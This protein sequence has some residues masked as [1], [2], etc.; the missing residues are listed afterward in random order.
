MGSF[1]PG[2][3]EE[4]KG[5]HIL[6]VFWVLTSITLV[7]VLARL[8]IRLRV[9]RNPGADDWL[10]AA[11]MIVGMAYTCLTTVN[12]SLGFGRHSA[13]IAD[14]L[15]TV[16]LLNYI[17]F[18]LGIL[19]FS[20][21]KLAVSALLTRLLNP[22]LLHRVMIWGL[23]VTVTTVSCI[24]IVVL[25]TMC[26]PPKALW[27]TSLMA[28]GATCRSISILVDYAIFTGATS[29]FTDL[30]LAIYP[31]VVLMKLHMSLRKRLAL[32]A[33]LG[34]GAVACAMAIVKCL[35]LPN[36]ANL[37]D[38]TY[39]TAD[40]VIWTSV[41][42]NVVILASCIPTLQPLI[43]LI[44]GKRTLRST[45]KDPYKSYERHEASYRS[46]KSAPVKDDLQITN[47]ESQESILR[48]DENQAGESHQLGH[49]RRTDNVVIEYETPSQIGKIHE[50][51]SPW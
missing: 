41:E 8:F 1:P 24:C 4:T 14:R 46:K 3:A 32:C 33:A 13:V 9:L 15:T 45:S 38:S 11:S 50:E 5:P 6:A 22:T 18:M 7:V 51:R 10:I 2:Y 26:D 49:I 21:P 37:A 34:L 29:A 48:S 42:S 16:L 40:L 44:L 25:F 20:L 35:Q 28:Q 30:V 23:S 43:E 47:I 36:L 17:D 19:A 27:Q 31:T 39:A 12:V